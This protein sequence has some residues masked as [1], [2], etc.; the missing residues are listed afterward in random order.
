MAL[1]ANVSGWVVGSDIFSI[2][3]T[4]YAELGRLCFYFVLVR[5]LSK[6]VSQRCR[7]HH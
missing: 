2:T 1:P 3:L 5:I 7:E 4:E 6:N